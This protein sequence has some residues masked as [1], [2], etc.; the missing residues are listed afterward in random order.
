MS[1]DASDLLYV[2]AMWNALEQAQMHVVGLS[3]EPFELVRSLQDSVVRQLIVV[4]EAAGRVSP[5]FQ[6][7]APHIP[8]ADLASL[9]HVL[10]YP[11]DKV[12]PAR[13]WKAVREECPS[14]QASLGRLIGREPRDENRFKDW[15]RV[16]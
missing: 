16:A 14:I 11:F 5:D 8:W 2:E 15:F 1:A 9:T 7:Q 6:G 13:I 4:A 12:P 3:F 10:A